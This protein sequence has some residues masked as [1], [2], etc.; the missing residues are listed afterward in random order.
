MI[1]REESITMKIRKIAV[2]GSG[3]MGS[4]IAQICATHGFETVLIKATAGDQASVLARVHKNLDK[5][6]SRGK[7]EE[8]YKEQITAR[9]HASG[10][11]DDAIDADLVIE[12]IVE[13]ID[14][15]GALFARL[16]TICKAE[17]I[18]A[19]NTSTLSITGIA[20]YVGRK[21]RVFGLHFFNPAVAMKLVE[22]IPGIQTDVSLLPA[23]LDFCNTIQKSPVMVK[24]KTGF[25]VNR[26]LAPYLVDAMRVAQEGLAR[27]ED[28]DA[29]MTMG[30]AHP[31]GPLTLAD[32]IGLDIVAHMAQN[33]YNEYG[34]PR[35]A[36]PPILRRLVMAGE[37]GR[38]SGLG[39]F[40]YGE[41]IRARN[42]LFG[43]D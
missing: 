13:E 37:L 34:E 11:L 16:D 29:A 40:A 7:I 30:C 14:R 41:E 12:S 10:S 31:M 5:M 35:L 20:K 18:L 2:I 21:E 42:E 36:P 17:T 32:Y 9:L 24:D 19:T 27:I 25:I 15:K 8:E 3:K 4:G 28:I 23:I 26:L 22:V 1:P 43:R 33:L 39:F 38:K 6:V